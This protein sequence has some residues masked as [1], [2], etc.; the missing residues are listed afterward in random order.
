MGRKWS[1]KKSPQIFSKKS[2][3][4]KPGLL[5]LALLRIQKRVSIKIRLYIF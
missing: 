5:D 1:H 2:K 4:T 3:T